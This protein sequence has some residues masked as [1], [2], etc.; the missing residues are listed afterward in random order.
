MNLQ[1]L[2]DLALEAAYEG[3]RT[4]LSYFQTSN[5]AVET[6]TDL[7]PVTV[8]DRAAEERIVAIIRG[9]HPEHAVLGEESGT[10]PGTE[11][12][13]WIIDPIDG[14]KSFIAGVPMYG[15]MIGVVVEGVPTI[16]VVS[17]PALG[18]MYWGMRGSGSYW[19]GRRAR[20]SSCASLED[21]RLLTTDIRRIRTMQ[22]KSRAYDQLER[23]V[24]LVRTWGD[25]YGHM[26]VA[27][28]RAEIMLDP[29]MSIWD[30]AAILPIIEEAGGHFT[31]WRG[32]RTI[33]GGDAISTN[34]AL[35]RMV[36]ET[37]SA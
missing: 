34:D 32:I 6:K 23:R 21:A 13:E 11:P 30:C 15:T 4:T 5:F 20:V 9:R 36:L 14:T 24:K 3:G 33:D 37:C 1:P 16:G 7:S 29:K 19:N 2:L 12:I 22:E 26:L 35:H 27:T 28:G 17:M 18:E 31:D 10:A 8:A 25:C